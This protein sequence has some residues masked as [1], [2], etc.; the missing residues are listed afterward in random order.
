MPTTSGHDVLRAMAAVVMD[1]QKAAWPEVVGLSSR[2]AARKI[3][4]DRPDVS[5]EFHLVGDNVPPSFDAHRVR[6]FLSP[7]TA[8]VAQTPVVG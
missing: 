5:L 7:A 2:M 8:K 4:G 3:H 1:E 6:I